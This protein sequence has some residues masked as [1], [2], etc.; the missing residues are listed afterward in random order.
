MDNR[1]FS[2]LIQRAREEQK[3]LIAYSKYA[4]IYNSN[5]I[6][7]RLNNYIKNNLT[8]T[9]EEEKELNI[10]LLAAKSL[11]FDGHFKD[12]AFLLHDVWSGFLAFLNKPRTISLSGDERIAYNFYLN[13]GFSHNQILGH[14]DGIDFT[15]SIDANFKLH[16][17][18]IATQ[19]K[20]LCIPQGNYYADK[21]RNPSCLG[22]Y[23]KQTDYP[24]HISSRI[25]H[26]FRLQSDVTV[27]KSI[28]ASVIDMWSIKIR[29]K[30]HK[31]RTKGG[32]TQYFNAKDKI[33]FQQ[34]QP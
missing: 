4:P 2:E 10:S 31:H 11:D 25:E 18:T 17:N 27:L 29:N 26:H 9:Q 19:W 33:Q 30:P 16:Q 22:V 6:L 13:H 1:S 12:Y 23:K 8:P 3:K 15:K 7:N 32:C 24:G 34:I 20:A 21:G 5:I 28:A 14:L